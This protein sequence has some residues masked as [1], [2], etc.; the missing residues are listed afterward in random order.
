MEEIA[1]DPVAHRPVVRMAGDVVGA[2]VV[3]AGRRV[4]ALDAET[5]GRSELRLIGVDELPHGLFAVAIRDQQQDVDPIP[6]TRAS[7]TVTAVGANAIACWRMSSM[8]ELSATLSW[9]SSSALA[10]G[11]DAAIWR[12]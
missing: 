8:T 1:H 9:V 12:T 6:T 2:H 5:H 7:C 10:T 4:P 11:I 3:G